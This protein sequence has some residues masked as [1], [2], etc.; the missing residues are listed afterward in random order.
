MNKRDVRRR[1]RQLVAEELRLRVA[2]EPEYLLAE[3]PE[4]NAA[5][6]DTVKEIADM[7]EGRKP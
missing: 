4:V 6:E 3:T 1:I 5:W 7:V 2:Q